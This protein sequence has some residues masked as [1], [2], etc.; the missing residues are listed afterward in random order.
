MEGGAKKQYFSSGFIY[1]EIFSAKPLSTMNLE[2]KALIFWE[3]T[4]IF[5]EFP[6]ASCAINPGEWERGT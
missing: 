2:R 5:S 4:L 3:Q 6:D 1:S